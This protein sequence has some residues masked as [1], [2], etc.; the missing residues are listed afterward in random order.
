MSLFSVL[1]PVKGRSLTQCVSSCPGD[2]LNVVE[3]FDPVGNFWERCQPM[4]TARSRVGVAV[5]NGLLY[6]IGGYDGQSRLS[7]VEVYNPETDTWTQ[8]SSMNSQRRYDEYSYSYSVILVST[9]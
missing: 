4:R 8:V 9:G 7:T 2:S 3:V 6:A 1:V 5:V